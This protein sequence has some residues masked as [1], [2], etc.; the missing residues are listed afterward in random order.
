[1]NELAE[2]G[3]DKI[4]ARTVVR[5]GRVDLLLADELGDL[6]LDRRGPELLFQ[7]PTEGEE[8]NCVA[9]ASNESFSVWTK[10][11]NDPRLSAAVVDPAPGAAHPAEGRRATRSAI[12]QPGRPP[13]A[14][15][16]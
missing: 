11:F 10:T 3:D 5:Y 4:L 12:E 9:I 6:E 1:M 14:S 16:P 15:E 8:K 2:A 7:F 13:G